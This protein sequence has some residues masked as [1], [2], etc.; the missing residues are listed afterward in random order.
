MLLYRHDRVY[1]CIEI[2]NRS[3]PGIVMPVGLRDAIFRESLRWMAQAEPS[4]L[5]LSPTQFVTQ[6]LEEA[7]FADAD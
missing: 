3:L 4:A 1:H 5:P 2:H 6:S 7:A